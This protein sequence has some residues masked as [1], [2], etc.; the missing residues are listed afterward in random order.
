LSKTTAPSLHLEWTPT[1]V[2]ATDIGT[3]ESAEAANLAELGTILSGHRSVLVGI[4]RRAVFAKAVRLPKAAPEDLRRILGVQMGQLFPLP[5]DLLAFDFFQTANQTAEGWLTV[6]AAMRAEDL[7]RLLGE[8]KAAGLSPARILPVALAAPAVAASAGQAEALVLESS[9]L[10]LSLDVVQGGTVLLSRVVPA[11]SD[12]DCEAKRTL[13][14]A[15]VTAL[16]IVAVGDVGLVG[17]LP[18]FGT[19]LSLLHEAP[20]FSFRLAEER[21]REAKKRAAERNRLAVLM[22]VSSLLL[23]LLV[24]VDREGALASAKRKEG[25]AA[26]QLTTL[27][28]VQD[29][30]PG[31]AQK[32][33]AVQDVLDRAFAPAQPLSDIVAVVGDSLPKGAWLTGISVERGKRLEFRGTAKSPGDVPQVVHALGVSPRFRDVKLVFANGVVI[34]KVRAVEFDISAVCVGNLPLAQP[35]KTAGGGASRTAPLSADTEGTGTGT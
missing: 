35:D 30:E 27:R 11:G 10:G 17:A 19:A 29:A 9:V 32:V 7:K 12:A 5:P 4:G 1:W 22:V 15:Q 25:V 33:G 21:T 2:R 6:V 34:G 28:S 31:K 13:A 23:V 16:P 24:W 20:E 26:R 18:S 3:R 8:L 14:A